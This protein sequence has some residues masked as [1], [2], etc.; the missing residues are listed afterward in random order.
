MSNIVGAIIIKEGRTRNVS[1]ETLSF[2]QK[3]RGIKRGLFGSETPS[4]GPDLGL[5]E[6]KIKR[7]RRQDT[8]FLL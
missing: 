8:I 4:E 6:R 1:Q 3:K 2:K 7:K 5:L